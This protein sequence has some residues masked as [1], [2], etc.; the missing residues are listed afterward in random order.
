MSKAFI[1]D[2]HLHV[3]EPGCFFAPETR[4]EQLL[5]T[6]DELGIRA[7]VCCNNVSLAEGFGAGM[8]EHREM[9]EASG[10]RIHYLGVF[11]P[12]KPAQCVAALERANDWPGFVG[13]K[14]HPSFHGV[15]VENPSYEPA[16]RFAADN[17]LPIMTHSWSVS[18]YNP[19]QYLSTPERFEGYVKAF[20]RVRLVL[21]H[22]GGRGT[23]RHEA[24][25]MANDYANVYLDIAGDIFD[26]QLI[27]S[28]VQTVPVEKIL[29][30]SDFPWLD[31]RS[32]LSHV[33]LADISTS[34]KTNILCENAQCV[35]T[36]IGDKSC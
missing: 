11:S 7:A 24:V 3:G 26:Y 36:R 22:A 33:L 21:A 28:L 19:V 27:E 1:I 34:D 6:M 25:R 29:F 30:G 12:H 5:A 9:F 35:Y 13:L 32:R 17:D 8:D 23:G 14:I 15:P 2:A 31:P 4:P 20:P 16:W 18:S 10:G